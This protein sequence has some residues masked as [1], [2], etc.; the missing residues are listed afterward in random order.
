MIEPYVTR[1]RGSLTVPLTSTSFSATAKTWWKNG[2]VET[3]TVVGTNSTYKMISDVYKKYG[4]GRWKYGDVDIC[5]KT[6]TCVP[7]A[8]GPFTNPGCHKI[9]SGDAHFEGSVVLKPV[10]DETF[11]TVGQ[12]DWARLGGRLNDLLP[13]IRP[14]T[15]LFV[16]IAEL[17]DLNVM[18]EFFRKRADTMIEQAAATDLT[19]HFALAPFASEALAIVQNAKNIR[20][21]LKALRAGA[22]KVHDAKCGLT[23]TLDKTRS[24]SSSGYSWRPTG[25]TGICPNGIAAGA[26]VIETSKSAKLSCAV[27]YRY[28]MPRQLSTWEGHLHDILLASGVIPTV[29]SMWE[30]VPFSFVLDWVFNTSRLFK[31]LHLDALDSDDIKTEI[32]DLCI[33]EKLETKTVATPNRMC[34]GF[35]GLSGDGAVF[36]KMSY[37]RMSGERAL[38]SLS[39]PW[40][41]WPSFTAVHLGASLTY[42]L[43]KSRR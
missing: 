7:H 23:V 19:Y 33:S 1:K 2:P 26:M 21:R 36:S 6:V 38:G 31:T 29:E 5:T 34:T 13:T 20:N 32:I 22:G 10:E 37:K 28:E 35:N 30:L 39:G 27:K 42:M 41:K 9:P 25:C 8:Y 11:P 15:D 18:I 40:L 14:K 12:S 16:F 43:G 3:S 17:R 4:A 24:I